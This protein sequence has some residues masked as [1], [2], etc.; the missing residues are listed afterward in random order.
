MF[1]V[2]QMVLEMRCREAD[3]QSYVEHFQ[4]CLD[5]EREVGELKRWREEI[6]HD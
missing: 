1:N 6:L 5:Q 2:E 4:A 3:Y